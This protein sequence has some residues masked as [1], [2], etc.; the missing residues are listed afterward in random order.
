MAWLDRKDVEFAK[1]LERGSQ[2]AAAVLF[3]QPIK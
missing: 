1:R 2:Q 3:A